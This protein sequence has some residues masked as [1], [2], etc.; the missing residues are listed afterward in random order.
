MFKINKSGNVEFDGVEY[1][2]DYI[3]KNAERFVM[4]CWHQ[5]LATEFE[6]WNNLCQLCGQDIKY[7]E[8]ATIVKKLENLFGVDRTSEFLEELG[9]YVDTEDAIAKGEVVFL[10]DDTRLM[11]AVV[12]AVVTFVTGKK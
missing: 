7:S 6:E 5:L 12:R 4:A 1:N 3:N 11:I 10:T 2:A 9:A 8:F